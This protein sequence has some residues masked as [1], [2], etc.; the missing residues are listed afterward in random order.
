MKLPKSVDLDDLISDGSIGL[1]QVVESFDPDRGVKFGTYAPRR[2]RGA[3][4][5]GL[6]N[7]DWVP[8]LARERGETVNM[9]S[10]ENVYEEN[11]R[12]KKMSFDIEDESANRNLT[13]DHDAVAKILRV[14]SGKHRQIVRM[15]SIEEMTMKE[16]GRELSLSESRISQ[17]YGEAIRSLRL[18]V[19]SKE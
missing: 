5:D 14:L 8:R 7:R 6:R 12:G 15:F 16:I 4:L 10:L 13:D 3:M 9:Q 11:D 2:I 17:I 19:N 18:T 1:Q